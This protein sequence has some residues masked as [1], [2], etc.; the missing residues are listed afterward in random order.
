MYQSSQ[1]LVTLPSVPPICPPTLS[2]RNNVISK[3]IACGDF[4]IKCPRKCLCNSTIVKKNH[5][6]ANYVSE[7]VNNVVYCSRSTSMSSGGFVRQPV[8]FNK[9]VHKHLSSS[10]VNN[11]FHLLILAKHF[12]Q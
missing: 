1:S 3:S 11:L 12:V 4:V 9:S 10:V 6:V 8:C 5:K 2:V 7:P